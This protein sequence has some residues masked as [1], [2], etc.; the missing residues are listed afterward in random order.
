[1]LLAEPPSEREVVAVA[2]NEAPGVFI[3]T[4]EVP[5]ALSPLFRSQSSS[6]VKYPMVSKQ[7]LVCQ[8]VATLAVLCLLIVSGCSRESLELEA[9]VETPVL[10]NPYP[11]RTHPEKPA[12]NSVVATLVPG[13]RVP[14][15]EVKQG[16]VFR[17]YRVRTPDGT[18][19][20]VLQS[21]EVIVYRNG[22]RMSVSP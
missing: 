13:D 9:V 22:S 2:E 8:S 14:V 3:G 11:L 10:E 1:M 16:K 18:E 17:T 19:G 7:L 4:S 20:Y 5:H 6:E 15:I 21:A 12:P